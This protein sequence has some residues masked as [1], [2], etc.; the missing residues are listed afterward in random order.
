MSK[1][2]IQDSR[3]VSW[4]ACPRQEASTSIA[5]KSDCLRDNDAVRNGFP[6]DKAKTPK[7]YWRTADPV[8]A[9]QSNSSVPR[10]TSAGRRV[11]SHQTGPGRQVKCQTG[12]ACHNVDL[13]LPPIPH[14]SRDSIARPAR[15][16][17]TEQRRGWIPRRCSRCF[18]GRLYSCEEGRP[19]MG[20]LVVG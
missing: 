15:T 20:I 2:P 1:H 12:L 16:G 3:K 19:E 7:W 9:Y 10:F 6:H 18:C 14:P 13:V 11:C 8:E 5:G 4:R 17:W